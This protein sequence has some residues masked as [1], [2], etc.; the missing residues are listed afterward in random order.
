MDGDVVRPDEALLAVRP[1]VLE[2]QRRKPQYALAHRAHT[3]GEA[4]RVAECVRLRAHVVHLPI[5]LADGLRERRRMQVLEVR[6][7]D[8]V[9]RQDQRIA[10]LHVVG[11]KERPRPE[12]GSLDPHQLYRT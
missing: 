8:E 1:R 7:A 6:L 10:N 12:I 5:P 9:N 2:L 4:P 3:V 11:V